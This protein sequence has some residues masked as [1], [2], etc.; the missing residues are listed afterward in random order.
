MEGVGGSGPR[1]GLVARTQEG[2]GR[3]VGVGCGPA[4]SLRL[5]GLGRW[6]APSLGPR[7][8]PGVGPGA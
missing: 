3:G 1:I 8:G 4:P 6:A 2:P 7:K 5:R